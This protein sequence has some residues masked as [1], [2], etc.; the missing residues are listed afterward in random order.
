MTD[1]YFP[2][3]PR[4]WWPP[5]LRRRVRE[6]TD[7]VLQAEGERAERVWAAQADP[8][9]VRIAVTGDPAQIARSAAWVTRA[10]R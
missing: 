7:D 6:L 10:G 5:Y 4:S 9:D 8:P 3:G 1:T 2:S